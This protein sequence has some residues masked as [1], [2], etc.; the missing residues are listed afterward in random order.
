MGT[1]RDKGWCEEGEGREKRYLCRRGEL[2]DIAKQH[3]NDDVTHWCGVPLCHTLCEGY[4]GSSAEGEGGWEGGGEAGGEGGR[5][6]EEKRLEGGR[7]RSGG[8]EGG[9]EGR[10]LKALYP[11]LPPTPRTTPSCYPHGS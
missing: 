9:L 6:E 2:Q 3:F 7:R 11:L 4:Q 1:C 8:R 10:R 5:G